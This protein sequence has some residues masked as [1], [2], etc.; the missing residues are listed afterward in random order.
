MNG[1]I[2]KATV[3]RLP[4]YLR[5]LE[6]LAPTKATVSSDEIAEGSG[7]TA[8]QVRK[9]LS[10]IQR[11]GTRGVGYDV[12][13]LRDL[14][15]RELG[16]GTVRR[17]ALIGAGNLGTAL[18]QYGGFEKRGFVIEGIYDA[19]PGRVGGTIGTLAVRDVSRLVGDARRHPFEI[20]IIA[21]PP[22]AAQQVADLLVE[23][24]VKAILNFAPTVVHVPEAVTIRRVDLATELRILSHY[25]AR[26]QRSG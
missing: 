8:A 22:D 18:A 13:T 12:A 10:H 7:G 25:I 23:A 2:P 6:E 20:G 16:L 21:T 15:S 1:P 3:A 11:A 4:A 9:D 19:N 26:E 14:I 17:V 5:F 24:G